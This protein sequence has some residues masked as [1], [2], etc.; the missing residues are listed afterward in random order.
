MSKQI[1]V[2]QLLKFCQQAVKDG[3][4]D[5]NIVVSDDNEGNGFH[6]L[7]CGFTEDVDSWKDEI[8]DSHTS[9]AENTIILG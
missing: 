1:T 2:K 9:D 6:G 7:F 4:G 3:H 8:Y 5:K